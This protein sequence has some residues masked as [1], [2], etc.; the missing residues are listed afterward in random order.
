[1]LKSKIDVFQRYLSKDW[2]I[3]EVRFFKENKS[4]FIAPFVVQGRGK[5]F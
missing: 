5:M 2:L 4:I 3:Y 1:M